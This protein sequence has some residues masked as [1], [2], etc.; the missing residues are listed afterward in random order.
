[1]ILLYYNDLLQTGTDL[2]DDNRLRYADDHCYSDISLIINH[3]TETYQ[4]R[5]KDR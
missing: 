4:F 5:N 3:S 1:M 2:C